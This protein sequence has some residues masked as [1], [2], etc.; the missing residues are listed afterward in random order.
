MAKPSQQGQRQEARVGLQ[1]MLMASDDAVEIVRVVTRALRVQ[2]RIL[3]QLRAVLVAVLL[4][5]LH[6]LP[7]H[8]AGAEAQRQ[9]EERGQNAVHQDDRAVELG[10]AQRVLLHEHSRAILLQQQLLAVAQ[11]AAE[12]EG[13]ADR[14][15][16]S[17]H[18]DRVWWTDTRVRR[19][20]T[21][22]TRR[23][24]LRF[25]QRSTPPLCH[26]KRQHSGKP[27]YCAPAGTRAASPGSAD[28]LGIS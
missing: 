11:R 12:A 1:G 6:Q 8:G 2:L 16:S 21:T 9:H 27:S 7:S 24:F 15:S 3:E 22:A 14:Q 4:R 28:T 13:A 5:L 18:R 25:S 20:K 17:R 19:S 10:H 26:K 23:G